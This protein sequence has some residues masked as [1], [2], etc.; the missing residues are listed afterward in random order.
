MNES[1]VWVVFNES[2]TTVH[3]TGLNDSWVY[4]SLNRLS[5][6][7][8]SSLSYVSVE[9]III[10]VL[11]IN[12]LEICIVVLHSLFNKLLYKC[13]H[14]TEIIWSRLKRVAESFLSFEPVLLKV[15]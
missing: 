10:G 2:F 13:D 6:F 5:Q 4:N 8:N 14:A 12:A 15:N 1:F 9:G 11:Q 7:W 3:K